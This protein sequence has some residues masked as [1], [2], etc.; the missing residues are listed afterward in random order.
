MIG[1]FVVTL[2]V[3]VGAF[4]LFREFFCWYWKINQVVDLLRENNALMR[5]NMQVSAADSPKRRAKV[6]SQVTE[7]LE[8]DS[9]DGVDDPDALEAA[10]RAAMNDA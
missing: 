6:V 2:V 10:T 1:A 7:Q 9:D 4:L 5:A 8:P 3:S